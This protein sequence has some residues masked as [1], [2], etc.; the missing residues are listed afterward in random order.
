VISVTTMARRTAAGE[1]VAPPRTYPALKPSDDS[2]VHIHTNSTSQHQ[3]ATGT[4]T[5]YQREARQHSTDVPVHARETGS[6][7]TPYVSDVFSSDKH[8]KHVPIQA[9]LEAIERIGSSPIVMLC[10]KELLYRH[11]MSS[12]TT[13]AELKIAQAAL[14][15][16][17]KDLM[18]R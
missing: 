17:K 13:I 15:E 9:V 8:Q 2:Q 3:S 6:V 16:K 10:D 18:D 7:S 1:E 4:S 14:L 12:V 5:R 11:R